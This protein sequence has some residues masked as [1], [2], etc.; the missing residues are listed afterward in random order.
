M[1]L[2]QV[3]SRTYRTLLSEAIAE[4]EEARMELDDA[5]AKY[6]KAVEQVTLL[7]QKA[8]QVFLLKPAD[9]AV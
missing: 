9:S 6:K 3:N 5:K 2:G 4:A 1:E 7:E 8:P